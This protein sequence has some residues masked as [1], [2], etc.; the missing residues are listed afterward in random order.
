MLDDQT[1]P[2]LRPDLELFLGPHN[3]GAPSY[4]LHDPVSGVFR[5][6]G[7]AEALIIEFLK[8]AET[9]DGLVDSIRN[10][11][12]LQVTKDEVVRFLGM[13][14]SEGL[15]VS[16]VVKNGNSLYHS[17]KAAKPNAIQW[18]FR[19]YL[20]LRIPLLHPD[21][22]L[23]RSLPYVRL[24]AS[25]FMLTI[26]ALLAIAG[27][28]KLVHRLDLYKS[29]FL[30][31]FNLDGLAYYIGALLFVKTIHEFSH[32]YVAKAHGVRVPTMGIAFMVFAP[33]AFCDVT[34]AWKLKSRKGRFNISVAGISAELVMAGISLFLWSTTPPG[35]LNSVMYFLSSITIVST[36]AVNLNPAMRFD[37]YYILS[38]LWGIDNLRERAFA[39]T[40]WFYRSRLLGIDYENP[41]ADASPRRQAGLLFYT[42]YAWLYRLGLYLGI[43]V[44]VYYKFEAKLLGLTL[45]AAE[46]YYFL[47]RPITGE[48]ITLYKARDKISFRG[49]AKYSI[50]LALI[51]LLWLVVPLPRRINLPST[52]VPRK[53]QRVFAPSSGEVI[54]TATELNTNVKPG[55]TLLEINSD[56]LR[57]R[58]WIAESRIAV[59]EREL[60]SVAGEGSDNTFLKEKQD[61]YLRLK[62]ESAAIAN[63]IEQNRIACN[64]DGLVLS[65]NRNVSVGQSI[66]KGQEV[67]WVVDPAERKLLAYI[68]EG[69]VESVS[70]GQQV[71]F[72]PKGRSESLEGI[73]SA[74]RPLNSGILEYPQLGSVH[75]GDLP[76]ISA[77]DGGLIM[78]KS[79]YIIEIDLEK[80]SLPFG[81][82]GEVNV[83][84]SSRSL[85]FRAAAYAW[86]TLVRESGF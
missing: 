49:S 75:K 6:L 23:A 66:A 21:R 82:T 38:D 25:R 76:V 14:A 30:Y 15:T 1:L 63:Q 13:L 37:G 72:L 52:L 7:W 83:W 80:N 50:S 64:V 24:L 61:T 26:Y 40:K 47:M 41:E 74:I 46:I 43:A 39:Y 84:T 77:R 57:N 56:R 85:A 81:V 17:H 29:T 33:V 5:H 78:Q 67:A 86:R 44:L 53:S 2:V 65:S 12:T 18:L 19:N 79:Y 55:E 69:N 54:F 22:F 51:I 71:E 16:S 9:L 45:F 62:A 68:T 20:Y 8:K 58:L 11:S 36:L 42:A 28:F 10:N 35:P 34:D 27:L 32:A 60:M 70:V 73:I 59:A 48:A 3:N 31:F 4:T